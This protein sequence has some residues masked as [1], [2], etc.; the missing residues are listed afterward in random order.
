M[1]RTA[2]LF[3]QLGH[4]LRVGQALLGDDR[5]GQV[6][7][8]LPVTNHAPPLRIDERHDVAAIKVGAPD[9]LA[10]VAAYRRMGDPVHLRGSGIQRD[11]G[12][13]ARIRSKLD[14]IIIPRI[15]FRDASIREAID[16]LRQQAAANDPTTE[17][18]RGVDIVLRLHSFGRSDESA[19][20]TA[21]TTAGEAAL[22]AGE[23]AP[24]AA[25]GVATAVPVVTPATP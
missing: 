21:T 24:P 8:E 16:F 20:V 11:A 25:G 4:Q 18:R 13:T 2:R 12:N 10:L 15:E 14:S 23:N 5:R 3:M 9:V 17:G 7:R 22:P 6:Q 19:P 1:L